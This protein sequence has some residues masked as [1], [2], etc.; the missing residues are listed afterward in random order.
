MK[1]IIPV[2]LVTLSLLFVLNVVFYQRMFHR[3]CEIVEQELQA[4][5]DQILS[6]LMGEVALQRDGSFMITPAELDI[7]IHQPNHAEL[8]RD[9]LDIYF[10][11]R[12]LYI[13]QLRFI[14]AKD[15]CYT[16][17]RSSSSALPV[18]SVEQQYSESH[19]P[20]GVYVDVE[21]QKVEWRFPMVESL[22]NQGFIEVS[23]PLD[24][25]FKRATQQ[26]HDHQ[27]LWVESEDGQ[28]IFSS[29]NFGHG[30]IS[31]NRVPLI[32]DGC[33][34]L[35][36]ITVQRATQTQSYYALRRPIA[37][38][39]PGCVAVL[40]V[41]RQVVMEMVNENTLWIIGISIFLAVMVITGFMVHFYRMV[42]HRARARISLEGV[43]KVI[44][45][46]PLG[47]IMLD[48]KKKIL[49]VNRWLLQ[50]VEIEDEDFFISQQVTPE[51]VFS[52]VTIVDAVHY[53]D[54]SSKYVIRKSDGR[55]V[56]ILNEK[57]PMYVQLE[58]CWVDSYMMLSEESAPVVNRSA[59][60]IF[61]ANISHELRTPLNGIIG[62]I[63]LLSQS[64][65]DTGDAE[66]LTLLK[67]SSDT[68]LSLINDILDFSKIQSGKFE[69]EA[70][71]FDLSSEFIE[72]IRS[73]EPRAQER[74]LALT[75]H[76][77]GALPEDFVGDP[78]RLRQVLNNLLSNAL[79][80]TPRGQVHVSVEPTRMLNGNPGLLFSVKDSGIGIA[81]E[82]QRDIFKSFQQA[83]E[84][85]TRKYGGTGLGTTIAKE[86][87]HLMGGEIWVNSP[88]KWEMTCEYPGSEFCFTLP[89]RTMRHLKNI[90]V[91]TITD[92]RHLRCVIVTDDVMQVQ[93]MHSNASALHIDCRIMSPTQETIDMLR[94]SRRFHLLVIDNRPDFDGLVFLQELY[95]HHLHR[96]YII[97]FQSNDQ[98]NTN[99][100]VA[101]RLGADAYLR[102]PV[103]LVVFRDFL[104]KHFPHIENRVK[105]DAAEWSHHAL[106]ILVA[107]DN[108]LNQ[109][110][111]H[112][113]FQKLG[114]DIDVATNGQ[115][116]VDLV[117]DK[118]HDIVFMD[119][120]MPVMDGIEASLKLKKHHYRGTIVAMTAS[121]DVGERRRALDAGMDD[122]ISKPARLDDIQRMLVKWCSRVSQA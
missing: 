85:T 18:H 25:F 122:F 103:K 66:I 84:S 99:T 23:Y 98:Q 107:E 47:V 114:F 118:Q 69:I 61:V 110:V 105:V 40:S 73:F 44:Y 67:R 51:L 27:L 101:R 71:P 31:E 87:V 70:I 10:R 100:G 95:N 22:P 121:N 80:F 96:N 16:L 82:K 20:F 52:R 28:V 14:S 113:L 111:I 76:V 1:K 9:R 4:D 104:L 119:V 30:K 106:R 38:I 12:G 56:V 17:T 90:P 43:R 89:I 35:H 11:T 74:G 97:L 33:G 78:I 7:L 108:L 65:A 55:E 120:Y 77:E 75:W 8:V 116:A 53:S 79:K 59:Q 45:Y 34:A 58:K 49:Q 36:E 60:N 81:K 48:H 6:A 115:E 15:V 5:L 88:V 92:F 46:L 26:L 91:D 42:Q 3:Q 68:L 83:D 41:P 21:I 50:L 32:S 54:V 39:G 86:L 62:M 72:T 13:K 64:R 112:N 19:K 93:I 102:K 57:I 37:G 109:K 117:L 94:T 29:E 2:A 63:D 24:V